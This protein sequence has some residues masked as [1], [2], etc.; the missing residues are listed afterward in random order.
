MYMHIIRRDTVR[1]EFAQKA[2][3]QKVFQG[4]I[5]RVDSDLNDYAILHIAKRSGAKVL[6]TDY[7][8]PGRL[9]KKLMM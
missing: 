7:N 6:I 3:L 1:L 5:K 9:I 2:D 4:Y 8:F